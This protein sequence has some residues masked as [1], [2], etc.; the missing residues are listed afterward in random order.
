[1]IH[2]D[3]R[4]R[5]ID[6]EIGYGV[7]AARPIPRGTITWTPDAFDL[8][9]SREAVEGMA[10]AEREIVERFAYVDNQGRFV[11]C[12]DFG[13]YVNHSCD[14]SCRS[15]GYQFELAI[16]D[17]AAGEQ[18][19]DDYGCMNHDY[20]LRC[21]CG[22]PGCRGVIRPDDVLRFADR[23]DAAVAEPFRQIRSV[24]QPLWPWVR[25][26]DEID[27]ALGG[28]TPIASCRRLYHAR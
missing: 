9:F 18:L 13:R 27:A 6:D 12:W 10:A 3:A 28:R 11:L 26:K 20:G 7:F 22:S 1:M 5:W 2:P 19:T 14:P 17:I 4:L 24:P 15:A 25:E 21:A 16:R 8:V 23:W